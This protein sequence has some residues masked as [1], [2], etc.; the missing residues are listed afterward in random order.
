MEEKHFDIDL[1]KSELLSLDTDLLGNY[2]AINHT[3]EVITPFTRFTLKRLFRFPIIRWLCSTSFLVVNRRCHQSPNAFIFNLQGDEILSFFAGDGIEDILILDDKIIISYFDEGV[4]GDTGPNNEGLAI[5]DLHGH[6]LYGFNTSAKGG[7]SIADCYAL[8]KYDKLHI[9]FYSYTDFPLIKLNIKTFDYTVF[10][11][12][13]K[14]GFVGSNTMVCKQ[15]DV[16][17]HG[18]YH[19]KTSFFRWNL[20]QNKITQEGSFSGLLRGLED[21]NFIHL[22]ENGF[23]IITL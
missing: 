3:Q 16:I 12:S 15:G 6:F 19:D 8:C 10:K 18:G 20:Y 4:F 7:E 17:F 5:F 11:T 21:G 9:L 2:I 1:G 23:T 22:N 13:S 14:P